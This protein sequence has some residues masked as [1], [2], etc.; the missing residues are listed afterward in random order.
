MLLQTVN[1]KAV[2][3]STV[4]EAVPRQLFRAGI[5]WGRRMVSGSIGARLVSSFDRSFT[6]EGKYAASGGPQVESL[7]NMTPMAISSA[8]DP[9]AETV[10]N[11]R[12]LPPHPR[13]YSL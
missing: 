11:F 13:G 10:P 6:A 12:V 4:L 1:S 9:G 2:G 7:S 8:R 5:G 3:S